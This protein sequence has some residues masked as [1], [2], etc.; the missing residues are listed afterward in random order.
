MH[1][2][3]FRIHVTDSQFGYPRLGL[4][5]SKKVSKKAVQ[6]NRIKRRIREAFR[7][8]QEQLADMDFIVI[9]NPGIS[10]EAN[11]VLSRE[12]MRL[13]EISQKKCQSQK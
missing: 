10:G 6:R 1:G 9:A 8:S 3:H 7:H 4:V 11:G 2:R 12:L 13:F 5:V